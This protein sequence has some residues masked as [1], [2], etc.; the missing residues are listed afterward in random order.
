M[1]VVD[2]YDGQFNTP[3]P[4]DGTAYLHTQS[5]TAFLGLGRRFAVSKT[6][7]D[8]LTGPEAAY[9]FDTHEKGRGTFDGATTWA[10]N[11]DRGTQLP[12]DFRLRAG[13]GAA[14]RAECQLFIWLAKLSEPLDGRQPGGVFPHSLSGADLSAAVRWPIS[15]GRLK[16]L[17]AFCV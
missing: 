15:G 16:Q 5:L 12:V 6:S 2:L 10:T 13:L 11:S 17:G 7:I 1:D 9:I 14:A 8:V 3:R 4:A